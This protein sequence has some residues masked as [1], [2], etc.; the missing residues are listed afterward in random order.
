MVN[1]ISTIFQQNIYKELSDASDGICADNGKK[2]IDFD[3]F[4]ETLYNKNELSGEFLSSC[5]TV[6]LNSSENHIIFV[7]FKDM[8]SSTDEGHL[9]SWWNGKSRSIYLKITDSLLLF[10]YYLKNHHNKTYD[11]FMN[12][13]KSFF[14]VYKSDSFRNKIHNHL[15]YKFSRY[16]FMFK[17]IKA[18]E[19]KQF[20]G[21]LSH[22]NL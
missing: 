4:V 20:E 18:L 12:T 3:K 6:L 13:P 16:N 1:Y 17:N 19:T 2:Y 10:S 22:N 14:Y 5:D 8:S 7:E 11:D 21:F 9:N 15:K